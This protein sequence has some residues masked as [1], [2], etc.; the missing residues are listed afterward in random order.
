M[1][2][3]G[4]KYPWLPPEDQAKHAEDLSSAQKCAL[5]QPFVQAQ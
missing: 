1:M 5:M 4:A 3:L 2:P